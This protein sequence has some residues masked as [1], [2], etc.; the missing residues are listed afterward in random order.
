MIF[1]IVSP[2]W[3]RKAEQAQVETC[4]GYHF[5]FDK[6]KFCAGIEDRDCIIVA[7][8]CCTNVSAQ[9]LCIPQ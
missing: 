9:M 1:D 6:G 8:H 2:V 5:H 3:Y 7:A 4:Y